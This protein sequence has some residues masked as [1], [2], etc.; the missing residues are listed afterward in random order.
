M[1]RALTPALPH[2]SILTFQDALRLSPEAARRALVY[3]CALSLIGAGLFAPSAA[4]STACLAN[5][6]FMASL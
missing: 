5:K 3:T 1:A 2:A 6:A 4:A